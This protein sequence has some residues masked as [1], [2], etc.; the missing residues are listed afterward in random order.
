MNRKVI[1]QKH[2]LKK[3]KNRNLKNGKSKVTPAAC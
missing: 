3:I 2:Q 1:L